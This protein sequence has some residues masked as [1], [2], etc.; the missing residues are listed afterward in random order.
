MSYDTDNVQD[1][2]DFTHPETREE[3]VDG[4]IVYKIVFVRDRDGEIDNDERTRIFD[5][6]EEMMSVFYM[7]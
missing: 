3:I 6:K 4:K 1:S 5:T 7:M 2:W